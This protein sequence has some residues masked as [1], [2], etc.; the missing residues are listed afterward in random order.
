MALGV[1]HYRSEFSEFTV[2]QSSVHLNHVAA[3][4]LP[5]RVRDA[6]CGLVEAFHCFGLEHWDHW[7]EAYEA[8]RSAPARLLN[9]E[10]TDI[11]FTKKTPAAISFVANGLD[12]QAGDEVVSAESE[13]PTNH[14]PWKVQEQKGVRLVLVKEEQ[15]RVALDSVLSALTPRTGVVAISFVQPG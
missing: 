6:M 7:L 5:R 11:A 10:I 12:W 9:A 8:T 4:P 14:Y 2:T 3:C 1:D 15:G 13:S